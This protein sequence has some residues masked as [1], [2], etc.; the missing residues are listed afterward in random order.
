MSECALVN[1]LLALSHCQS[2]AQLD[3]S[4]ASGTCALARGKALVVYTPDVTGRSIIPLL[5]EGG[6]SLQKLPDLRIGFRSIKYSCLEV[7]RTRPSY[8]E[9]PSARLPNGDLKQVLFA[10]RGHFRAHRV[11]IEAAKGKTNGKYYFFLIGEPLKQSDLEHEYS[12]LSQL[13]EAYFQLKPLVSSFEKQVQLKKDGPLLKQKEENRLEAMLSD[14]MVGASAQIR[15]VRSKLAQFAPSSYATLITGET[16]TG[17][18]LAAKSLHHLSEYSSGPF[19][20]ENI[21]A[22]PEHLIESE[23][24]GYTKGAFT[25]ADQNKEGLLHRAEGGTLFLDEI[26]DMRIDLQVKLLRVLQEKSVRPLGSDHPKPVNFRLVTATH[27]DLALEINEGRFRADLFHRISQLRI[28]LPPLRERTGD[29]GYLAEYFLKE[30][31]SRNGEQPKHLSDEAYLFLDEQEFSGNI[32]E[33]QNCIINASFLAGHEPVISKAFLK[34][35]MVPQPVSAKKSTAAKSEEE[36]LQPMD[37]H[38]TERGLK[39]SVSQFERGILLFAY[40]KYAGNRREMAQYL[41]LPQRTLSNKLSQF[42]I[43]DQGF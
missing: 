1:H 10:E 7:L 38:L 27:R 31:A 28:H 36:T 14:R 15:E 41:N 34:A 3:A 39:E 6:F 26:G 12:C 37:G 18:E 40:N 5:S 9:L 16:G 43:K 19:I 11:D 4:F 29:I 17:K 32:R 42:K 30:V 33:L 22:L 13:S 8:I 35:S 21:S 2:A 23:L 20:A 24:F 25:G